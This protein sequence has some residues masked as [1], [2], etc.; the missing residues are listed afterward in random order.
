MKKTYIKPIATNVAFA[1]NENIATSVSTNT[2]H[3]GYV[4][5]LMLDDGSCNQYL[6]NTRVPSGIVGEI[7]SYKELIG[8]LMNMYDIIG[9]E[10][11]MDIAG[12]I[13]DGTFTCWKE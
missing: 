7:T 9:E 8:S 10:A 3:L 12:K 13:E 2:G 1:M 4:N 5:D 11:F 6:A